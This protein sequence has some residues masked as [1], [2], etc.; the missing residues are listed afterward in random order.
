MKLNFNK[1][2]CFSVPEKLYQL[3]NK[4]LEQV[5][6]PIANTSAITLN[7]RD[8]DYSASLGGYHPVEIHLERDKHDWKLVYITD[9]S[10]QGSPSPELTKELDICF[11]TKQVFSLFGG[12]LSGRNSKQLV[13]MFINNFIE[14]HAMNVYQTSISFD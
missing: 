14:Y 8:L 7:F 13:T 9:F 10:Y 2:Q 11:I 12:W 1:A 3:L 6:P 4:E 5:E